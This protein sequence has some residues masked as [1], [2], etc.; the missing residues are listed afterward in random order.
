L[1]RLDGKTAL[2]TGGGSGIGRAICERFAL[3]GARVAVADWRRESAEETVTRIV[4]EGGAALATSGDV[5]S[6]EDAERMVSETVAA[7][8][9]LDVLST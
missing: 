3:E 5:A 8:G 2:V 7:Y 1:G 9:R 4:A 6:P